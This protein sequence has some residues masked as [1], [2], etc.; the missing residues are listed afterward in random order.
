MVSYLIVIY[1]CIYDTFSKDTG[2]TRDIH[3]DEVLLHLLKGEFWHFYVVYMLWCV[4][5]SCLPGLW[6]SIQ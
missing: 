6:E 1:H 4:N 2:H 3:K 5:V